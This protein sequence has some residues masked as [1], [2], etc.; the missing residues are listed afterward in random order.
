MT[1]AAARFAVTGGYELT[2]PTGWKAVAGWIGLL[3]GVVAVYA[4]LAL[5]LESTHGRTVLP[6]GRRA[7][8]EPSGEPVVRRQL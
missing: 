6:F 5:A 7:P 4:A 3:L 8:G 1:L 2:G